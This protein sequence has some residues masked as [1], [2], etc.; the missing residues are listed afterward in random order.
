MNQKY[1]KDFQKALTEAEKRLQKADCAKLF[2][3]SSA[4]L[5]SMLGWVK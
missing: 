2:G 1:V 4:D 3:K 5:V